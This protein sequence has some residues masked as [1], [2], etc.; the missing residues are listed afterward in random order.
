MVTFEFEHIVPLS[1]G[2]RTEFENLCLACPTCNRHKAD[3]VAVRLGLEGLEIPFFHPHRDR[4]EEHFSW[5]DDATILIG[6][7]VTG[8]VTIE[9]FRMNRQQMLRVRRI[10]TSMNEHPPSI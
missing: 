6:L 7:T 8:K 9:T 2:G 5:N 4:W 10:W 3:R 1:L